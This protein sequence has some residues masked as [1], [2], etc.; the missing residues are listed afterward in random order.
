MALCR[1]IAVTI[2]LLAILSLRVAQVHAKA[3]G[4]SKKCSHT[5][6]Y[7]K[8]VV[9]LCEAHYPDAASKNA[10]VVQFYHPRVQ[11][12]LDTKEAFEALAGV[13]EKTLG[14]KVGAV[15]CAQNGEFCAKHGIQKAPTTRVL[16]LGNV[17]DFEGE[18]ELEALQKFVKT[19]TNRFQEMQKALDC[20][21]RSIFKDPSKDAA[22]PLCT[23]TF[24]LSTEAVPWLVSFY[25]SGDK[26]KD[27]TMRTTM[28]KLAEKFG[29]SPPKKADSKKPLR[30]RVGAVDCSEQ[31]GCG[32]LGATTLPTVRF[33]A[34]PIAM[35]YDSFFDREEIQKWAEARLKEVP[36]PKKV[37][38]LTADMP[39]DDKAKDAEL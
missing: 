7:S 36:K 25:E 3:A 35:D 38:V 27:K 28:N 10:W 1:T 8:K 15:D 9:P 4:G 2:P 26:N 11:K 22:L 39:E 34:D 21:V 16:A 20:K 14:A 24:P 31:E 37:A 18:H 30:M 13:S 29:N 33:Y 5:G 23:N 32:D 6:F 12:N 19:T 17:R